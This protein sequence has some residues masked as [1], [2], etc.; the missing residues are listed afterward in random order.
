[1]HTSTGSVP[2]DDEKKRKQREV[3][4]RCIVDCGQV[5]G[6]HNCGRR[7]RVVQANVNEGELRLWGQAV[8][9]P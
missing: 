2:G 7:G 6:S 9:L 4:A 8:V 5:R 1:V 3:D